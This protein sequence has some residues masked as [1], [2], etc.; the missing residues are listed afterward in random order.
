MNKR[1]YEP[2]EIVKA[3]T[4]IVESEH[5]KI[6]IQ[7][8]KEECH[9]LSDNL[10]LGISK[11]GALQVFTLHRLINYIERMPERAQDVGP[12]KAVTDNLTINTEINE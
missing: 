2:A 11:D 5:G 7:H 1:K 3:I 9:Y 10:S 4:T 8:L 12:T 6:L